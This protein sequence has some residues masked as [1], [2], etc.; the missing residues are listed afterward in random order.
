MITEKSPSDGGD[1]DDNDDDDGMSVALC[2]LNDDDDGGMSVA[3]CLRLNDDDGDGGDDCH[4]VQFWVSSSM[5]TRN[6]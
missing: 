5:T 6:L 3:S 1:D 4:H 2:R